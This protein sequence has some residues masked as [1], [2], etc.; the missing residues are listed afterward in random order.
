[1][2]KNFREEALFELNF[3]L[4]VLGDHGRFIHD[5]LS[6]S[7][8]EYVQ[9]ASQFI[10]RFDQLLEKARQQSLSEQNLMSLLNETN[11]TAKEL[12]Q[13]KLDIIEDHL[14]GDVNIQLPPS[15]LN[16]MVN[17]LDE[18]LR[19]LSY[20]VQ[21]EV[22]ADVHPL[23]HDLIWLLDAAGHANAISGNLDRVEY[24]LKQKGDRFTKDWEEFYLKAVE[25]VGYLRAN[26]DR[27]PALT[28]FHKDIELEMAVF[29]T[30]LRELEEMELNKENLGV[31]SPLMADH[32]AREECYYLMKL[33][34]TTEVSMPECDP[35]K[36]RTEA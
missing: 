19:V 17:E 1:M 32:M 7:E 34:E 31:L 21:G 13:L 14:V 18:A 6:P 12:R 16:H 33:A 26:V 27:F 3:W 30:F 20:L 15:F 4:Q 35:T 2:G 9:R 29:K 25:M 8:K 10:K 24:D 36:P 22:P 11:A 28:R 5:S 23:H